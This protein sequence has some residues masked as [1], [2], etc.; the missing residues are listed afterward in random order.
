M[1]TGSLPGA[2]YAAGMT[3][4]LNA[5]NI[6]ILDYAHFAEPVRERSRE[7]AQ[8]LAAEHGV[9]IQ[10]SSQA[11]VRKEDVVAAV[12]RQRGD[13]PGLVHVISAMEACD[14]YE[15]WHD[16]R[17]HQTFLRHTSGKCM[18][19]YFCFIDETL[20]LTFLRVPTWCPFRLQFYGNGH[21][22]LARSLT[23]AGIGYT[24]AD[25]AFIRIDD[26][27]RAQQLADGFSPDTLHAI[28]DSYAQQ[29][30]P[31]LDVFAQ[32]DHWSLM[33][34]E[35]STDRVFRSE[36]ILKSL[37][38]ELPASDLLDRGRAGGHVSWARRSRRNWRRKSAAALPRASKAPVSST[39]S[40]RC[41]SKCTTSSIG[42]CVWKPRPTTFPSSNTTARGTS[43]S[44]RNPRNR[45]SQ[46]DDLQPHRLARD[47]AR[48]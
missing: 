3:S 32:T 10:H 13:Q 36:E 18:D 30:C 7:G 17:T 33:Q 42:C 39:A 6:R 16:K 28:L 37:Y 20:G 34:V 35:Y 40:A 2:C 38:E 27:E 11:H 44:P 8:A 26:W 45:T 15:P 47:S 24:L 25:N 5:K 21:S 29:C 4:F 19:Y 48:L 14:A 23:A 31:V 43:G 41:R 46:E 12:I 1:I 22:W 9:E